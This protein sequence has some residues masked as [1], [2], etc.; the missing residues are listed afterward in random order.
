M[1]LLVPFVDKQLAAASQRDSA[2]TNHHFHCP[3]LA[4]RFTTNHLFLRYIGGSVKQWKIRE[5]NFGWSNTRVHA[6]YFWRITSLKHE[7]NFVSTHGNEFL[8]VCHSSASRGTRSRHTELKSTP[9]PRVYFSLFVFK[10]KWWI[11]FDAMPR[12]NF[13][14][15]GF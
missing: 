1:F 10:E 5:A 11:S 14:F 12:G 3:F 13:D 15:S 9:L 6:N 2:L 4:A 7:T 8:Y